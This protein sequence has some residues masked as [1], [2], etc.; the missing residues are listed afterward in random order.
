MRNSSFRA[1]MVVCVWEGVDSA[2]YAPH[3]TV[4]AL[5]LEK[6][7]WHLF[8]GSVQVYCFSTLAQPVA[9]L[10][11]NYRTDFLRVAKSC[12]GEDS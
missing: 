12:H 1:T 3:M 2:T 6:L 10:E 4:G 11:P 8:T 7:R 9:T 5:K